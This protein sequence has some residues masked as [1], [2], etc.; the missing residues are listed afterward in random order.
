[1][2]DSLF[3]IFDCLW[4]LCL[5]ISCNFK[6]S[7]VGCKHFQVVQSG[8]IASQSLVMYVGTFQIDIYWYVNIVLNILTYVYYSHIFLSLS[9]LFLSLLIVTDL[10]LSRS[11]MI[12]S[13]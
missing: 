12:L 1:M 2:T 6:C 5:L 3:F 8:L 13:L 11:G 9:S 7:L 10:F 4:Q